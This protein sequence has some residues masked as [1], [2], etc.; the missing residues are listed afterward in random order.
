MEIK[1]YITDS[2]SDILCSYNINSNK[3]SIIR[4]EESV[5]VLTPKQVETLLNT[6]NLN[7]SILGQN[8]VA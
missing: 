5:I 4:G 6:I 3:V 1:F 8:K 2:G 7:R